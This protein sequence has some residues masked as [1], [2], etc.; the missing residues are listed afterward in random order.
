MFGMIVFTIPFLYLNKA[1]L[2]DNCE[3]H[4]ITLKRRELSVSVV[5]Y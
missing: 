4:W 2:G 5:E 3:V 1:W